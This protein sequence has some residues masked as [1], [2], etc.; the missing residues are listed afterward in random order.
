MHWRWRGENWLIPRGRIHS[1]ARSAGSAEVSRSVPLLPGRLG[2]YRGPLPLLLPTRDTAAGSGGTTALHGRTAG[3]LAVRGERPVYFEPSFARGCGGIGRRTSLRGWRGI[4]SSWR[5]ESSRPHQARRGL[6]YP[7]E[8]AEQADA[9]LSKSGEGDLV[10][11]RPPPSAPVRCHRSLGCSEG[12]GAPILDSRCQW[13]VHER[14]E[15]TSGRGWRAAAQEAAVPASTHRVGGCLRTTGAGLFE[16]EGLAQE[17]H[18]GLRVGPA[19]AAGRR[20]R[21]RVVQR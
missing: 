19:G 10:W 15:R 5:F 14:S 16:Q 17:L 6:S 9:P 3:M 18:V 8:V 7:A 1:D 12:G 20:R 21:C 4:H 2:C 13:G 11:V